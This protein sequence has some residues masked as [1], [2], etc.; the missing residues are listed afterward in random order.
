MQLFTSKNNFV[1]LYLYLILFLINFVFFILTKD[2]SWVSDDYAF[3]FGA[4]LYNL[5]QDKFFFIETEPTRF[6]PLFFLINQFIPESYSTWHFIVVMFYFF[7]SIVLFKITL[8]LFN[9]PIFAALTSILF[10][11][12]YSISLDSLSWGVYYSHIF[13]VFFGLLSLYILIFFIAEKNKR[14]KNIT[15]FFLFNNSFV[16][17]FLI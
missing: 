11:V 1:F 3:I 4:K 10:S 2:N 16:K 6:I 15:N 5:I 17:H 13:N 12:N 8:K 7:T 14:K 9:N